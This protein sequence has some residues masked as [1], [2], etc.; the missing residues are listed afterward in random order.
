MP[1]Y[2]IFKLRPMLL[3][4]THTHFTTVWGTEYII[5]KRNTSKVDAIEMT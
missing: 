2:T 1:D 3:V 4:L 5:K